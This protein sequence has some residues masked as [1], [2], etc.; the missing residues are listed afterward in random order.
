MRLSR[1]FTFVVVVDGILYGVDGDGQMG[2]IF[3]SIYPTLI[4][5]CL[6]YI[7]IFNW[8]FGYLSFIAFVSV[9]VKQKKTSQCFADMLYES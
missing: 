7:Y 3:S 8:T 5:M 4:S 6:I 2:D 9:L 1:N